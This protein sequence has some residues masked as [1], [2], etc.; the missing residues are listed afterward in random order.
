MSQ[1]TKVS[2]NQSLRSVQ[3][4]ET[5]I[6]LEEQLN[7]ERERRKELEREV[8]QLK[9]LGSEIVQLLPLA[10]HQTNSVKDDTVSNTSTIVVASETTSLLRQKQSLN[11]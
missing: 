4:R 11:F 2:E 10:L 5:V 7:Y 3:S 8:E 9:Q 6:R 1:A